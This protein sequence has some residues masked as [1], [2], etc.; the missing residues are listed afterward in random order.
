MADARKCDRCGKFYTINGDEKTGMVHPSTD[1]RRIFG[2]RLLSYGD[3]DF[4]KYDLCPECADKLTGF[5][6]R[7]DEE[8]E[9]AVEVEEDEDEQS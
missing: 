4:K 8:F 1:G 6:W 2:V 3:W 5:L 9:D 7:Y